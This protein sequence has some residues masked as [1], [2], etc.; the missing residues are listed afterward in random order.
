MIPQEEIN[1]VTVEEIINYRNREFQKEW[2]RANGK[3]LLTSGWI[4]PWKARYNQDDREIRASIIKEKK[5][6]E[7]FSKTC[8]KQA[9]VSAR[10]NGR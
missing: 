7:Q 5:L 4:E 2:D 9:H 6:I 10:K 8:V 3:N 1:K